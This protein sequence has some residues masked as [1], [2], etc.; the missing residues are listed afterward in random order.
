MKI[1]NNCLPK[2]IADST[3]AEFEKAINNNSTWS[4][5]ENFWDECLLEGVPGVSSQRI[6]EGELLYKLEEA[7]SPHLPKHS[8][9]T[10]Q[11]YNWHKMSGISMHEDYGHM[12]GATLYLNKE[13]NPNWGGVFIWGESKDNLTNAIIPQY[14]TLVINHEPMLPHLVTLISPFAPETRKTIQIWGTE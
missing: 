12:F 7:L 4:I 5:S 13:W 6:I 10:Y 3:S 11:F 9:A 1:I 14:N 8:R 2:H